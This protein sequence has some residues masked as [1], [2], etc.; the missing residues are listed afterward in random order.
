MNCPKYLKFVQFNAQYRMNINQ[1]GSFCQ[2]TFSSRL[3]AVFN[4]HFF[5]IIGDVGTAFRYGSLSSAQ[6]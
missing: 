3:S 4:G 2:P 6:S 5:G 1:K